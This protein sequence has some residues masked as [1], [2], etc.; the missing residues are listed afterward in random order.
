MK[1]T[2]MPPMRSEPSAPASEQSQTHT[3]DREATGVGLLPTQSN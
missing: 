2:S 1:Q 3:L